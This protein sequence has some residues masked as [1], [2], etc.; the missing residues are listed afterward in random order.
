M[1]DVI[2]LRGTEEFPDL[3]VL[4]GYFHQDSGDIYGDS[5]E[6][7]LSAFKKASSAAELLRVKSDIERFLAER[8]DDKQLD[9]D[10]DEF[11]RPDTLF[12]AGEPEIVTSRQWFTRVAQS[13]A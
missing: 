5:L 7:V 2:R 11:F 1:G 3:D 8:P 13:L 12:D 4:M 6:D 10:I 9:A